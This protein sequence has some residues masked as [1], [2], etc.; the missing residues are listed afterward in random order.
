[1]ARMGRAVRAA[2]LAAILSIVVSCGAREYPGDVLDAMPAD[3]VGT[4]SL[5]PQ[6]IETSDLFNE[7]RA[8]TFA[9]DGN[10]NVVGRVE[11][12]DI[13]ANQVLASTRNLVTVSARAVTTLTDTSRI[14]FPIDEH[15]VEAAANDPESGATT[16][17]FNSGRESAFVS[18]G[19]DN[20]ASS[21]TVSGM[22]QTV[23]YCG[24]RHF[25]IANDL[26]TPTT[27]GLNTARLYELLPSGEPVVRS[28]WREPIEFS[29]ASRASACAA[30][31]RTLVALY[32]SPIAPDGTEAGL[33]MVAIDV[34][35][36]SRS[37]TPL[38]M[39]GYTQGIRRGSTVIGDR[40]YWASLDGSVLSVS[41]V[42]SP[43]VAREWTIPDSG[44]ESDASVSG[45]TVTTIDH[46]TR[47]VFSQ[48]DLRTGA[49][50]KGPVAL[51]WLESIVDSKAESGNTDYTISDVDGLQR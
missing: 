2:G 24:D 48:Y 14:E 12:E 10:G 29:P 41:L 22:V 16:I 18:I 6:G 25:A 36:G 28:E 45:T 46:R 47:P 4:V 30:D 19:A 20:E 39:P 40:L 32:R 26:L 31:G 9:F 50:T 43:A 3:A 27:D 8:L 15:M 23:T 44:E 7:N 37:E 49:R 17:W 35:D 5:G 33:T 11:G 1:M 34:T 51:P 21:G 38:D 13:Y 42:G